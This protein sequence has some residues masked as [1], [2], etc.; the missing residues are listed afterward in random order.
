VKRGLGGRSTLDEESAPP[1]VVV[2]ELVAEG[3]VVGGWE[4]GKVD[5]LVVV[6]GS[7][8]EAGV[9][10]ADIVEESSNLKRWSVEG[11]VGDVDEDCRTRRRWERCCKWKWRRRGLDFDRLERACNWRIDQCEAMRRGG[12]NV[13]LVLFWSTA[14][15]DVAISCDG[16][17][18]VRLVWFFQTGAGSP[19]SDGKRSS[20]V[21]HLAVLGI[22]EM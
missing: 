10:T 9:G 20:R 5:G 8:G 13:P 12:R 19:W 1:K 11:D 22:P 3:S 14:T 21:D 7:E 16:K 15:A 6:T 18:T 4:D 2:V 17:V